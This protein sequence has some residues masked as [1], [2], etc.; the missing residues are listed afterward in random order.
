VIVPTVSWSTTIFPIAD[1]GLVPVLVDVDLDTLN[2]DPAATEDA[3]SKKSAALMPVH[4][5]GNPPDFQ[6]LLRVAKTEGLKVIE[7]ACEAHGASING[8]KAGTFGDMASFSFYF[9]H[10]ISTI[11]GGML[12]TD[13]EIYCELAKTLR[14]HGYS[15]DLKNAAAIAKRYSKIDARFLFVNRGFNLRPTEINAAF[16]IQQLPKLEGFVEGR[17]ELAAYL[18]KS[19]ASHEGLLK[20]QKVLPG[21]RNVYL[22]FSII[23]SPKANFTRKAF[24]DHLEKSGI[25][26][27]PIIAGN[28]AE[29]PAMRK[30]KHRVHG[31]LKNARLIMRQGLYFGTHH[32]IGPRQRE[33]IV[34]TVD[35]FLRRHG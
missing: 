10:H 30:I 9:S 13:N 19:L 34:E 21:H 22:G 6:S 12:V 23:I 4:V 2:M 15:R 26:T 31:T 29:H 32:G 14:A 25:E 17:R 27:R 5:L 35:S 18:K 28:M 11:E 16:G 7:D 20:F 33:Y 1:A 24:V 3:V 8:R